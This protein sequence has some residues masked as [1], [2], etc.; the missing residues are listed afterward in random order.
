LT[1]SRRLRWGGLGLCLVGAATAC[2]GQPAPIGGGLAPGAV[3]SQYV[4]WVGEAGAICQAIP[5]AVIAAQVDT[6][7]AWNPHAVS[8]AGADGIAQFLPATWA[9]YGYDADG[10]GRADIWDPADAIVSMGRYDCS[11]ANDLSAAQASGRLQGDL[12][13]LALAAYNAGEGAVRE[14]GGVP[15][16]VETQAYVARIEQL[17]ATYQ[18][19]PPAPGGGTGGAIVAAAE[20]EIGMPYVY[21]G[22]GPTGPTYGGFD[23]SG[24]TQYA[25]YQATGGRVLLPRTSAAQRTA[26]VEV[27]RADMQPGDLIVFNVPADPAPWGHVGIY[28]GG[29]DM[30]DAPE[31]G[32]PV[33]IESIMT[34]YWQ[35]MDWDV[36]R[37]A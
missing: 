16:Y 27:P 19:A 15:P 9:L 6:E 18:L 21:G 25:V 36:R 17:A 12:T 33:R 37:V 8:S 22:G 34:P 23:C 3:P 13:S 10:D 28:V 5:S 35:S 11:L 14:F 2:S 29:G 1:T 30:V 32:T 20:K 31:P 26:G 7:S 24:L 4:A